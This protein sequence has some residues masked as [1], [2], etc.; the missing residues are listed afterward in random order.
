MFSDLFDDRKVK[1]PMEFEIEPNGLGLDLLRAVYR[2][3]GVDLSIRMRAAMA[4][5]PFESPKLSVIAQITEQ[6]FATLLD[7][8]LENMKRIER[9]KANARMIEASVEMIEAPTRPD[10][11]LIE[12]QSR[13]VEVKPPSVHTNDKRYRRI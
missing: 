4:C 3:P 12:A 11:N 1:G 13:Q 5:L 6:D 10:G 8:R 9:N 2:N 7:R